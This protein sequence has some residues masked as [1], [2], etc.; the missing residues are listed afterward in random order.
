MKILRTKRYLR[1]LKHLRL[2]AVE[3]ALIESAIIKNPVVGDV[4][5]GLRGLRK[6]RF[7]MG[8][9][10]KRGGGRAIYFLIVSDGAAIMMFAYAKSVKEDLYEDDR[11]YALALMENWK[12]DKVEEND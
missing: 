12:N 4:I 1:D 2:T 5:P 9:K 7:A 6:M 3:A 10:G 11:K 8:N